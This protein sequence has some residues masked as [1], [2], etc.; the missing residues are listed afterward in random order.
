M[1]EMSGDVG[2]IKRGEFLAILLVTC[3]AAWL[4]QMRLIG[5]VVE[6]GGLQR[7][8]ASGAALAGIL[9]GG[10]SLNQ[11]GDGGGGVRL[12]GWLGEFCG[13]FLVDMEIDC[14][15]EK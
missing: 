9:L 6:E 3:A 1:G 8:A 11:V 13:L 14:I 4:G 10:E 2:D 5:L 12:D 15:R 7:S